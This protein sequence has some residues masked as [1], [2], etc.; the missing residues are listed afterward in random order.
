MAELPESD[1]DDDND[2][3]EEKPKYKRK[4]RSIPS[5]EHQNVWFY[6]VSL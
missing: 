6:R 3:G 2:G 1:F 4:V 5:V